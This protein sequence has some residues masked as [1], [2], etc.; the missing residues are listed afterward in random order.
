MSTPKTH[1]SAYQ[2]RFRPRPSPHYHH[3]MKPKLKTV[4]NPSTHSLQPLS[5]PCRKTLSNR[6]RISFPTALKKNQK[7]CRPVL[8]LLLKMASRL[9]HP[10]LEAKPTTSHC[11]PL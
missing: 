9:L 10:W 3:L 2:S 6:T 4:R 1:R 8:S 5:C 11:S 7:L